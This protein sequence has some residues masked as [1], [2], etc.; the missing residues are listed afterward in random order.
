MTTLS[1]LLRAIATAAVVR[2]DP[3]KQNLS[4][5]SMTIVHVYLRRGGPV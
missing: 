3:P 5:S 4:K 1:S 2:L